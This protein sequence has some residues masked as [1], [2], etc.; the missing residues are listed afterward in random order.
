[1]ITPLSPP[2]LYFCPTGHLFR[3]SFQSSLL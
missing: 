1:V 3:P 2:N